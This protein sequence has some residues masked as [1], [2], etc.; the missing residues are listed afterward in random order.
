MPASVPR[1][2]IFALIALVAAASTACGRQPSAPPAKS[3]TADRV[4]VEKAARRLTLMR[5]GRAIRTY[6]AVLGTHP[7]GPKTRQGDR[8]TPEGTY[9]I[10]SRMERSAFHRSLHIS[11]PTEAERQA[12]KLAGVDPG[13]EIFIHG[14][15]N[16]LGWLGRA[17]RLVDWTAGCIAVTNDEIEEIWNLVPNGTVIEIRP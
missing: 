7:A 1:T 10:D 16:G 2:A 12:A 13:G 3:E 9:V 11:Y 17:H 14:I 5:G 15:R 4:V 6:Q 8:R